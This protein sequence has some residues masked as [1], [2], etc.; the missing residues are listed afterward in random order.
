[1]KNTIKT[2]L[3]SLVVS[4]TVL[5]VSS[6]ETRL[7]TAVTQIT[8]SDKLSDLDTL[9][10]TVSSELNAG[11]I[12][13]STT[14]LPK[15]TTLSNLSTIGTIISGIWN[16]TA[17]GVAY[18]G[19][20]TTT[21][22]SNYV[23]LGNGSSGVKTVQGQGTSGQFLTS[24]G[25]G[26]AP[27][28]QTSAVDTGIDYTWTGNHTFPTTNST[29]GF[30]PIGSISAYASTTPPIGWL[31]AD[32]SAISRSTYANLYAVIGT[33]YGVGDGSTTFNLPNLSGREIMG[34]GSATTTYDV[35][36][37]TYGEDKHTQTIAEMPAH[38]HP[39]TYGNSFGVG[40]K[41][42][43]YA[44]TNGSESGAVISQG[45]GTAFNVLD[46]I[47]VLQYIIKY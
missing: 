19:T 13:V 16:G 12:D 21:P 5:G 9:I 4:L 29:G 26:S 17:I 31:N 25:A 33:T 41:R 3:I 11:K 43:V 22:A 15:I 42:P 10:N 40:T 44:E 1:M 39:G 23:L 34:F 20:G 46:P 37:E 8:G 18:G 45:S 27:T 32:G 47:I 36:G 7:G 30:A 28:W 38:T 6:S 35:L 14:T 24:N 2:I